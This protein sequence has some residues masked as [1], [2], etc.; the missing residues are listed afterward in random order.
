[1]IIRALNS[2]NKTI[3]LLFETSL[4]IMKSPLPNVA[5]IEVK[6]GIRSLTIAADLESLILIKIKTQGLIVFY[7]IS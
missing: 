2:P 3:P 1:M 5:A 6:N 4:F 7:F